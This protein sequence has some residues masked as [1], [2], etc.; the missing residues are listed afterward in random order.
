MLRRE[1]RLRVAD[2]VWVGL[3]VGEAA[4]PWDRAI[5]PGQSL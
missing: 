4:L 3:G 2:D 5:V 1:E